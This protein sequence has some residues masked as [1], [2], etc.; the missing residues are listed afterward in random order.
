MDRPPH[1][2]GDLQPLG[3]ATGVLVQGDLLA[4]LVLSREADMAG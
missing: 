3:L 2:Q 1:N 4:E